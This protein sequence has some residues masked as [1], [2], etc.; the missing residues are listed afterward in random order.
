MNM[1]VNCNDTLW[2]LQLQRQILFICKYCELFDKNKFII[3]L[4]VGLVERELFT[5]VI[6]FTEPLFNHPNSNPRFNCCL[7][8]TFLNQ[9]FCTKNDY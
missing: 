8:Q 1:L 9:A 5:Y 7:L 3:L 2:A 4:A 6:Q